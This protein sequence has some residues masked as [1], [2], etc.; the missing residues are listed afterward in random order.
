MHYCIVVHIEQ[1]VAQAPVPPVPA[2]A[3]KGDD[4]GNVMTLL[5]QAA[6]WKCQIITC[7]VLGKERKGKER[8]W[9][10]GSILTLLTGC[11]ASAFSA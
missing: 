9:H 1:L 5:H 2:I 8:K 11:L 10:D 3:N 4:E 6:V 7:W